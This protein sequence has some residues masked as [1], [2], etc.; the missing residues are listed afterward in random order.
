MADD[1]GKNVAE[2]AKYFGKKKTGQEPTFDKMEEAI[3]ANPPNE[4]SRVAP[5]PTGNERTY[6]DQKGKETTTKKS[7]WPW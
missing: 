7:W 5:P 4:G 3:G 1:L 2:T 6:K